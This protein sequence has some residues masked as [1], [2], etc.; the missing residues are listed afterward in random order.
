VA[1]AI[2]G[3]ICA[4]SSHVSTPSSTDTVSGVVGLLER[5]GTAPFLP[6]TSKLTVINQRG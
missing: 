4:D 5:C 6:H 1:G 2:A 3:A